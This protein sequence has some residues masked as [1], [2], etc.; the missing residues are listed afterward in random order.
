MTPERFTGRRPLAN[1]A[2][3]RSLF[4]FLQE[5]GVLGA[6]YAAYTEGYAEDPSGVGA[7]ESV[8]GVPIGEVDRAWRVWARDVEMVPE[9]VRPGEAS[10]GVEVDPGRGDGPVVAQV[11][12]REVRRAGLKAGD[13]ITAVDG[14]PTRDIAE[15]VRILGDYAVGQVVV[16]SYRRGSLVGEAEVRLVAR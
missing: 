7:F 13:A 15:L 6:W 1:Y 16:V 14:R 3:A 9:E 4:L 5:R 11:V 8:F 12:E 10:L 2:V